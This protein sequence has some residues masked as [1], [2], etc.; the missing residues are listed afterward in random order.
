M[1]WLFAGIRGRIGE[2]L[3]AFNHRP[4]VLLAAG[5]A[6]FGPFLGV[7]TSLVALK[8]IPA[9]IAATLNATTPVWIIPNVVLYY[10]E[11]VT[12]R[13]VLGALIAVGGV[14]VLFLTDEILGH[15]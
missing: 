7:W 11:H 9:G 13:A 10:K 15:F 12:C 2:V 14:A 6:V 3:S 5:G 4:A 8:F 1:I